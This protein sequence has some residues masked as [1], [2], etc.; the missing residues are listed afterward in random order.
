MLQTSVWVIKYWFI[1]S[2]HRSDQH[3][4]FVRPTQN[5]NCRV[6]QMCHSSFWCWWYHVALSSNRRG[7]LTCICIISVS[8]F[9]STIGIRQDTKQKTNDFRCTS[10]TTRFETRSS[11]AQTFIVCILSEKSE[12]QSIKYAVLIRFDFSIYP[13]GIGPWSSY[14]STLM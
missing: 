3:T 5:S 1:W 7:G 14:S 2:Y 10:T 6:K 13:I 8:V 11:I 4:T 12:E 9:L